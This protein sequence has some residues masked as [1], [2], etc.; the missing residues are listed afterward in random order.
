MHDN[1]KANV[2][3]FARISVLY[4]LSYLLLTRVCQLTMVTTTV[5]VTLGIS[6][7]GVILPAWHSAKR[8]RRDEHDID[9]ECREIV[10]RYRHRHN[11][12]RLMSDYARWAS[13]RHSQQVRMLFCEEVVSMLLRDKHYEEARKVLSTGRKAAKRSHASG[14]FEKFS[15]LCEQVMNGDSFD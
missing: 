9:G 11:L 13:G 12:N 8:V 15:K 7:F 5:V 14:D 4:V 3:F 10:K 2:F 6:V 1:M